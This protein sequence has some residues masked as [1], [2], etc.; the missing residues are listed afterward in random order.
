[1]KKIL[2]ALLWFVSSAALAQSYPSPTYKNVTI[3]GGI[4]GGTITGLSAPIPFA[5][6]GTN[7]S[8]A[9]GATN[10]LQYLQGATGSVARSL[11]NKLQDSV[12]VLDFTGCDATGAAD[13]TT[14]LQNV[15]AGTSAAFIPPGTYKISGTLNLSKNGQALV[16]AG[17]GL[18]TIT[19]TSTTAPMLTATSGLANLYV[20]GFT[21]T[22]SV[23]AV[24]GGNGIDFA[25]AVLSTSKIDSV[26]VNNQWNGITLGST[27]FSTV[28]NAIVQTN[29]NYGVYQTNTGSNGQVQWYVN[30]LLSQKNGNDGWHIQTQTGPPQ[31]TVGTWTAL[32]TFANSGFG[33][34]AFGSASVPVQDVRIVGGFL[35]QDAKSEIYLDTY[36][37]QHKIDGTFVELAG[38]A[39]TGPTLGTPASNVGSGIEVTGNN[40]TVQLTGVHS[41]GNSLDGFYLA[42]TSNGIGNCRSMNN[43][44]AATA[45]RANGI[46]VVSGRAVINGGTFGNTGAGTSQKY[47]VF[48]A[49]GNNLSVMGADLSN[50][51]IGAWGATSNLSYVSSVGNLPNTLNVG[52]SP[53]GTVLVGGGATGG[54]GAGAGTINVSGGLLKN[55]TAYTN[56]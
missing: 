11:T 3:T 13:S 54:F 53:Q 39:A 56:P 49:D 43:G 41:Y 28:S 33:F 47:G 42:A 32:Y 2:L 24:P 12:S 37:D 23:T 36:G 48:V 40:T 22:R 14:C 25:G 20:G 7:A 6:G 10:Q 30:N 21:L 15:L 31:I 44:A 52:L 9:T 34:A 50:N 17:T 46:N 55:N 16:G 45:G 19:S 18:V 1:M 8:T 35:G 51:A 26:N 29:Q 4:T 27:D 38:T 5:S